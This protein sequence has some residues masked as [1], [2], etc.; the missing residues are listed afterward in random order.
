MSREIRGKLRGNHRTLI[1][2]AAQVVELARALPG[3]SAS[4]GYLRAGQGGGKRKV[5]IGDGKGC[6][7]LTV[8]QSHTIQ[9]VRV[10]SPDL[11]ATK[12]AL[13]RALRNEG[14]AI[15]FSH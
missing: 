13:S 5:K 15:S 7:L 14:I 1:D 12:L 6:I 3:V 4:P 2:L 8:R 9:E 11:Q 10:F